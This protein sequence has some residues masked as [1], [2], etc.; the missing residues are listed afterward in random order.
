MDSF[1]LTDNV[2]NLLAISGERRRPPGA[3]LGKPLYDRVLIPLEALRMQTET[4]ERWYVQF[5]SGDVRLMSLDELAGAFEEGEV[6]ENTF[7]IQVGET[8]W[9]TL[10][11][12]AG[13]SDEEDEE[14]EVTSSA[15]VGKDARFP[16][17][18]GISS[19]PRDHSAQLRVTKPPALPQQ[20]PEPHAVAYSAQAH[21]AAHSVAAARPVATAAGGW[22]PVATAVAAQQSTWPPAAL[23]QSNSASQLAPRSL[24]P[25]ASDVDL[26]LDGRAFKSGRKAA[27]IAAFAVIPALAG[28]GYMLTRLDQPTAAVAPAPTPPPPKTSPW[29]GSL[30]AT[31]MPAPTP[32]L[33]AA[34]KAETPA[35][36]RLS[37][38]TKKALLASDSG[39]SPKAK[40][41]GSPAPA[42]HSAGSAAPKGPGTV[43]KSGGHANDPLNSKL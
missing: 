10:A 35:S 3:T 7:V 27:V 26:E 6:H 19:E 17:I 30:G 41:K 11:A 18:V 31:S 43:F 4:N 37:D 5:D 29:S 13:L 36:D 12:V 14:D 22:P 40:A 8:Q 15:E 2:L 42:R 32:T 9:Q 33:V 34:T 25:V 16:S 28:G 38:E 21:Q 20:S 24:T 1:S 39:R 23:A